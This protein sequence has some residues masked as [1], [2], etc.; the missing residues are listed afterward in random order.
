MKKILLSSAALIA[1][2]STASAADLAAR[3]YTK[4][5]AMVEV[6]YNWTGLYIGGFVGGAGTDRN[7][8]TSDPC[9]TGTVCGATGFYNGVGPAIYNLKS[10]VIGGGTIGYNWQSG[11]FV[12]GV[13]AEG[14]YMNL[15]GSSVFPGAPVGGDTVAS[16]RIG[17]TYAM[18]TGRLGIAFDRTLFYVKGGGVVTEVRTGVLD[19]CTVAPCGPGLV[20]TRTS[21]TR[22][23]YTV[24]G[25]VEYA[26]SSNWSVKGEYMYLGL[27]RDT[28]GNGLSNGVTPVYSIT[29]IPG[30]HMGKI[31]IN[32]KFGG[33]VVARY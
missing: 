10:S 21:N 22:F 32:Y 17:D 20:N 4:A 24:G 3:P 16:T 30:V 18:I 33:P 31:G 28:V 12:Y 13:E 14:G 5:P 19:T 11:Q 29:S 1:F 6:G 7:L 9:L 27:R 25:G 15:R 26:L 2:I 8:S 23:D